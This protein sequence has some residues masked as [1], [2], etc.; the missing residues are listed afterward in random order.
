MEKINEIEFEKDILNNLD[1]IYGLGKEKE[2]IINYM[3]FVNLKKLKQIKD[4]GNY[5]ICITVPENYNY[6]DKLIET[7]YKILSYNGVVSTSYYEMKPADLRPMKLNKFS[8]DRTEDMIVFGQALNFNFRSTDDIIRD[9]SYAEPNKVFV[10]ITNMN[11]GQRYD[12][13][14]KTLSDTFTWFINIKGDYTTSEKHKYIKHK[15]KCN[16]LKI[17]NTCNLIKELE[18]KEITEI[19]KDLLYV[20]VKAKANN[21]TTIN[22]KFL[23]TLTLRNQ[24]KNIV[25]PDKTA[26]QELDE[27]IGL[28]DVKHR[29]KQIV[30]YVKVNKSRNQLPMLH[31]AF[32]G[33]PGSG[34]T[35]VARLVGRIFY[36][37]GILPKANFIEASRVDLVGQYVG[38]TAIKTQEVINTA[39]GGTLLIDEA[40]ALDPKDSGK[41]FGAESI[42]TLI[43]AMEDKRQELCVILTGYQQPMQDLLKSNCGFNS[44]IQFK[45]YFKDYTPE[46][47]YK[48]FKKMVKDDKYKLDK[49]LKPL[50]LEHFEQAQKQDDFGNARYARSMLEKIKMQQAQRIT[51]DTAAD[52]DLIKVADIATVINYLDEE[53][54]KEKFK[55][56]FTTS[57]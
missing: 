44:R 45:L 17:S 1:N 27:L 15:L 42:S 50:L 11:K 13:L 53:R 49:R 37:E 51:E 4:I 20:I 55:I 38:Q 23:S 33:N 41:D 48:I 9:L 35:E 14:H 12:F 16:H 7:I 8:K 24:F 56:G 39:L 40:Y 6:I 5:N 34:K 3:Q 57:L 43:K 52:I 30:N 26:I 18:T 19:E 29:I 21:I 54:P 22:D 2:T 32:L 10:V 28:D 25:K 47:L 31:M 46:E 36:E